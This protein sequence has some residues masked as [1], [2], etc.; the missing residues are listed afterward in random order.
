ML[1]CNH[2]RHLKLPVSVALLVS[3][4]GVEAGCRGVQLQS[5]RQASLVL[6]ILRNS[7]AIRAGW[8]ETGDPLALS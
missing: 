4:G 8:P 5:D 7:L 6:F 3:G 2:T 1:L